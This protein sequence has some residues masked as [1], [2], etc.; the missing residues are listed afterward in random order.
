VKEIS[1][2]EVREAIK[3]LKNLKAPG[4][5]SIPTEFIK[6]GGENIYI[7]DMSY[8]M[9]GGKNAGNLERSNNYTTP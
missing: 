9:V 1:K 7:Q 3:N 4:S 5:D 2:K 8:G 6:Y